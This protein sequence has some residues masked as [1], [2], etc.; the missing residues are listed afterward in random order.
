MREPA[1]YNAIITAIATGA[2]RMSE[3]SNKVGEDTNVCSTYVKNLVS[4]GLIRKE[5][6]YGERTS[7]KALYSIEDNMFRFWYRFGRPRL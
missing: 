2:A 4:L 6:P 5:I 7:R 1:L 3:I